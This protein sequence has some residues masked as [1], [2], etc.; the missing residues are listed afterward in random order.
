MNTLKP[1]IDP[2]N[3][4]QQLA[5]DLVANTNSSFFLT[6]RAGTG[7]TTFLQ[8][9]QK[10]V[11]KQFITLAPTGVA[12]ILAGGDTIHSFFGLPLDA[13]VPGT[14]GTMNKARILTLLH[15]DTIIIDEVSMVRCDVMDAIDFTMRNVLRN[16]MTFGGK[17]M[18]FVGDMFQL[19]P[20]TKF[21]PERDLL[22]DIYCT[23]DFFFYKSNAIK[24]MRLVKIEFVKPY[25]QED[26]VFLNI[27]E[28]VRL[29][30]VTP[31]DIM[32]LNQR[33]ANP[34]K[35]DGAIIT[36]ASINKTA[37]EI[38]LRHLEEID[39]EEF[40]YEGTVDGKFEEKRFPVEMNLRLKVGAQVM[41]TRNDQFK[42]WANGTLGT[43]SKLTKDEISVTLNNGETYV[44][45]C[46][47]WDSYSYEYKKEERKVKKELMGTFC[48]YPLKL[49]W[50]ITIHKS[51]GMTF[52]KLYL[53][54]SW[55]MFAAGQL[56][57]ALSR[58]RTLDGLFLSKNIMPQYAH[59]SREILNYAS[60]YNNEKQIGNEI[61]SGKVV[62]NALKHN[63]YDEAAKGY[64]LL[65]AKKSTS[66][67][68]KE[69]LQQAKRFLDILVCDEHLYGVVNE[70]P[71]CLYEKRHW[72]S[73]FL[74][75]L[76]CLYA[77]Q[78]ENALTF[79]NEVL[80]QHQCA[81]AMFI[82]SRALTKMERYKEADDTN[83]QLAN[84]FDMATVDAKV[85]F[86]IAMLNEMH[87]GE[88]GMGLMKLLI[89][90]RPKYD[91]GIVALR[92]LMKK[93]NVALENNS[94]NHC[95]LVEM[96]NS[97]VTDEEFMT[98]LKECRE[99]APKA[100]SL[101]IRIIK[102]QDFNEQSE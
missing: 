56:Y 70:I 73:C 12:A 30:R 4:E 72:T 8:N 66:G 47:S 6:G 53:D 52:D 15:A 3:H 99:K 45:P 43:V 87:I 67:D 36:L 16:N 7:K 29:N 49:A 100:V 42:R 37:E 14:R 71:Q 89:E 69:A 92:T 79:S 48:Q 27:L 81:E 97:D 33:V 63:D 34:L 61:E 95:E 40:V 28:H 82:K 90:A 88:P 78:Y 19:P 91:V 76:L 98:R 51:Q 77:G 58:V 20:V 22:K 94:D 50:A 101:L 26:S 44:V 75:S 32:R 39:S 9:V 83:C 85:L 57:V 80:E 60:E 35:E 93:N 54:L 65:V 68:I 96:F 10:L 86:M 21:G 55:G 5:Y 41:F 46:C 38:N 13:C 25:R 59:T 1:Q 11:D 24:Q 64:L 2:E 18:I 62:F 31:E 102:K 84:I 74:A 17:Q 23:E